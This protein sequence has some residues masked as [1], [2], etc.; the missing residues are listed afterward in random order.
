V[1]GGCS[2][3]GTYGHH[4]F[5]MSYDYSHQIFDEIGKGNMSLKP[6][7]IRLSLHP[8]MTNDE[9]TYIADAIEE[10]CRNH[11]K[12]KDMYHYDLHTNHFAFVS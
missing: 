1:R 12:Y 10:I 5:N 11:A 8:T 2:C 4:L 3:A 9:A 6:G 7:W